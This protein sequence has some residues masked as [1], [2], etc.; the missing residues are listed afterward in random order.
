MLQGRGFKAAD[1]NPAMELALKKGETLPA[2]FQ[3]IEGGAER[4]LK[5]FRDVQTKL[6][7]YKNTKNLKTKEKPTSAQVREKALSLL[8]KY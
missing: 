5:L 1:I 8:K 3:Q 6:K 4:G 7:R 2:A